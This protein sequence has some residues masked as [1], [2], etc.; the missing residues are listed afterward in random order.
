MIL[1]DVDFF[2]QY[3]DGYGHLMGDEC[4]Q[5]VAQELKRSVNRPADLVARYGGEEFA[6]LLPNTPIEGVITVAEKIQAQIWQAQI[7]HSRSKVS[8]FLTL[9]I[10]AV[11][12]VPNSET[13]IVSLIKQADEALY[14]AKQQ[15]RDRIQAACPLTIEAK[16]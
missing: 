11:S 16:T 13:T 15:G 7:Q 12:I 1:C 5:R 3:N 2:K 10:G 14:L 6:V 4:L 8:Q 9:S